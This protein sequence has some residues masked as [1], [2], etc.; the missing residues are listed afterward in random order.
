MK[1]ER[2]SPGVIVTYTD[3]DGNQRAAIH[4]SARNVLNE[5]GL[6]NPS[7]LTPEELSSVIN[8]FDVEAYQM[9]ID[10]LNC[11]MDYGIAYGER[12]ARERRE[13]E[14]KEETEK[15]GFCN[16]PEYV[17]SFNN[18]K[19]CVNCDEVLDKEFL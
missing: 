17:V 5:F 7:K 2:I 12:L 6:T 10:I 4:R 11:K 1:I 19:V 18:T 8:N 14:I 15:N 9:R 13:A 3:D 16:H